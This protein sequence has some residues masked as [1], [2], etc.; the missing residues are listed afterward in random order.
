DRR[1]FGDAE[2]YFRKAVALNE[3]A[4]E[5]MVGK[6]ARR[7]TL[8]GPVASLGMLYMRLGREQ[9]AADFLDQGF[10][11]DPLNVRVSNTGKVLRHLKN[12]ETLKTDHFELRFDPKTDKAQARYMAKYLEEIYADLAGKFKYSPKGPILIEVFNNHDMFSGRVV[13]LPD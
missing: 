12:Y 5:Q 10:K 3:Q 7:P 8:P 13:A 6:Q 11:A 2:K 1:H 9:E 4:V